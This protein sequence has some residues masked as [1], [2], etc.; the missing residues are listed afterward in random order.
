MSLLS[1]RSAVIPSELIG[2]NEIPSHS[3]GQALRRAQDDNTGLE[4]G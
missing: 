4:N 3:S 2:N 1:A